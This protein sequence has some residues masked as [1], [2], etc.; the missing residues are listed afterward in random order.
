MTR[1]RFRTPMKSPLQ[2]WGNL[3]GIY[4]YPVSCF[5]NLPIL[6]VDQRFQA[7]LKIPFFGYGFLNLIVL[8]LE[9]F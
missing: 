4:K 1:K 5:K 9:G 7:E 2:K 8:I 6:T 3:W